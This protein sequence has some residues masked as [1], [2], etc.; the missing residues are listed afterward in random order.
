[1]DV[2]EFPLA[3]GTGAPGPEDCAQRSQIVDEASRWGFVGSVQKGT[4]EARLGLGW[5][6]LDSGLP[7]IIQGIESICLGSREPGGESFPPDHL[8]N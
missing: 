8:D 4:L 7:A 5:M 3:V 1:M 2:H 6:R